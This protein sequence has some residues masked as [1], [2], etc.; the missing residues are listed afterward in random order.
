VEEI[1]IPKAEDIQHTEFKKIICVKHL[2]LWEI[3]VTKK[4][5]SLWKERKKSVNGEIMVCLE[6]HRFR[7][8]DCLQIDTAKKEDIRMKDSMM[9]CLDRSLMKGERC[10]IR[11]I[12]RMEHL[13]FKI[14]PAEIRIIS[15]DQTSISKLYRANTL[16]S[17]HHW[18]DHQQALK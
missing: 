15:N 7:R 18:K 17:A 1:I 11:T 2:D 6:D 5:Y 16:S 12:R 3:I 8:E 10:R 4:E 13:S 9:A 14:K